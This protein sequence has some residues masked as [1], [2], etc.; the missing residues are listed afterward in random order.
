MATTITK[1]QECINPRTGRSMQID[2]PTY[3]LFAGAITHVLKQK[4]PLA[5]YTLVD[6]IKDYFKNKKI[7]FEKSVDWYA[8]T[9]KN[10]MEARGRISTITEKRKKLNQLS[11]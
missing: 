5:F 1:K 3:D 8:I 2:K 9:V 10:D 7:K 11:K 4:G 6:H